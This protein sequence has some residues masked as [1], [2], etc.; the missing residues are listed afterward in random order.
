MAVPVSNYI[1]GQKGLAS[2]QNSS[3]LPVAAKSAAKIALVLC[4]TPRDKKHQGVLC[5]VM[6][7]VPRL[8]QCEKPPR[9]CGNL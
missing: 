7:N 6:N 2:C 9:S 4:S 1:R 8:S 3:V 5:K